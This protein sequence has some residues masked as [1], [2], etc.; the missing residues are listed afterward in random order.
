MSESVGRR[1]AAG[2]VALALGS[3]GPLGV[4][5]AQEAPTTASRADRGKIEEIVVRAR[6]RDELLQDTPVSVT[7]LN[8]DEL[9][10][11]DIT[12]LDDIQ[13][14]V[15]N[16]SFYSGRSGV[17]SAVFIRGVGQVDPV[18][19]FDP[20]VG[21]YVDGV[22]MSRQAGGV[23][24]MA[25]VEQVEVLRG[26]QGTLFGKNTVGG[27]ILVKTARPREEFGG[28]ISVG[29]GSFDTERVRFTLNAPVEIG[30]LEDR[31]F[32]RLT[33]AQEYSRGYSHNTFLDRYRNDT[34]S[35]GFL[36]ALRFLA[37]DDIELNVTGNWFRDRTNGKGSRCVV[38]NDPSPLGGLVD[39]A[40][41]D[42]C[43][44]SAP[45][46]FEADTPGLSDIESYGTWGDAVWNLG[47]LG[48]VDD[49]ALKWISSW[50][51]QRPRI[52]EDGDGTRLPELQLSEVGGSSPFDGG[53]G[54]QRQI[55]QELQS[56]VAAWEERLQIV[57]GA[58]GF[59]EEAT[60]FLSIRSLPLAP[61]T[62]GATTDNRTD[63]GNS[64]WALFGQ[65]TLAPVEWLG[66]T[67]G[68]RYTEEKKGFRRLR[69]I[70]PAIIPPGVEVDPLVD[71]DE[72]KVFKAWTPMGNV[73]LMAP[74]ELIADAG[75]E[76]LLVYFTYSEGF[77]SGGF[78]GNSLS[79]DPGVLDPFDPETLESFE[80]GLKLL[81]FDRRV[82]LN[83]A[84]F[85]SNYDDI[86][87]AVIDSTLATV[88][89]EITVRNAASG[90]VQGAELELDLRPLA[91]LSLR[92]SVAY[93]DARYDEFQN[94]PSA[95][96][97]DV[98]DRSGET[99]NN[100]P[101][102]ESQ[103]T[104][105]Y[106][107]DTPDMPWDEMLGTVTPAIQHS[108]R[109]AVH[110]QGPELKEAIQR[111][112]NLLHARLAY[113]FNDERTLLTLWGRNLT[114]EEY[115]QQNFPTANSVGIVLQYYEAPRSF[116]FDVTHRF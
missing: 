18:I 29:A 96:N 13:E 90:T 105:A 93:L 34:N 78:N 35:L 80:V 69:T 51:E 30:T 40:L 64:S 32:T 100:V 110:Y 88:L 52:R 25:D 38:A 33:F 92:G 4:L 83:A 9:R 107:F 82:G 62:I 61:P 89:P 75:L 41:N 39:P 70:P 24:N 63:V 36:G 66:F 112:Y 81:G 44:R 49:L 67:G 79:D 16:L 68:L 14:L 28:Q 109:S 101:D 86:Q 48:P 106:T 43:R 102:L 17:T 65:A 115:F 60:S 57:A 27:A 111:G 2:M 77:K 73:S 10:L 53:P 15:P 99:F 42:E 6:R 59:W 76:S 37:S 56:N 116:G 19:T 98:I 74:D 91:D 26:P 23:L 71:A 72:S 94:A 95:L 7:A 21:I 5:L 47:R 55:S 58:F 108:Y 31:L 50:R 12:R 45:F 8:A 85:R 84:L 103:V 11:N 87:V 22:F 113:A 54:Y 1:L 104:I 46:D 97:S 20:G 3:P 114:D